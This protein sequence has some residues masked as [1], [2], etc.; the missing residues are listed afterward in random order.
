M[1]ILYGVMGEG[2]GHATR[3]RV[4]IEHLLERHEVKAIASGGAYRYLDAHLPR[5][6]E[7]LGL[8]FAMGEGQIRRWD[9]FLQ[10]VRL[11]RSDL[12]AQ[13]KEFFDAL[14]A[15]DPEVVVTDFEPL[16]ALYA[17]LRGVPLVAVDNIQVVDRC[18]HARDITQGSVDD[19]LL[20]RAVVRAM[21][22][23]AN[24]YLVTTFFDA[25]LAKQ[26]TTLIPPILRPEIVG[27]RAQRG[28]HLLVYSSGEKRLLDK[29]RA[30]GVPCRVYGM[31][32][33]V[34]ETVVDGSLTFRPKSNEGFVE[35]LRT[36]R[37][38]V[39]GGG[40]SLMTEAIYLGKPM[41]AIPLRGQFEQLMN[42]R[43]LAKLGYGACAASISAEVLGSFVERLDE[44][45]TTLVAYEQ[46]GN[47]TA[48]RAISEN[49]AYAAG[50]TVAA[51]A[52]SRGPKL[53]RRTTFG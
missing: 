46:D 49:L 4:A 23:Q 52:K 35:D 15:W 37:A 6:R 40:F 29:L 22:P 26:H 28:D 34:S 25:P 53:G 19:F 8:S 36:A 47:A 51:R 27:A 12:P 20:S 44:Y 39:A 24:E 3:S 17:R 50:S 16:A 13:M 2:M 45:E 38:V 18:R 33:G 5:V 1:R 31:R 10:N 41:L 30:S 9:T 32:G 7:V 11:A 42:A 14:D 21:V 43:Y 48:L